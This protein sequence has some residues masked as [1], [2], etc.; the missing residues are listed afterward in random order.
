MIAGGAGFAG[1]GPAYIGCWSRAA[2]NHTFHHFDQ[3]VAGLGA[4][5]R[6]SLALG[7]VFKHIATIRGKELA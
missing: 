3:L 4:K 6:L 1:H 2:Q 7:I 5:N